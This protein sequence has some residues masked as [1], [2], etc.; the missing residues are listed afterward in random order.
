MPPDD[1]GFDVDR[2][3]KLL[4][5]LPRVR[6]PPS[7]QS[8][9]DGCSHFGRARGPWRDVGAAWRGVGDVIIEWVSSVPN[10]GWQS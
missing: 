4:A 1:L 2:Y 10:R 3:R 8:R 7:S 5:A 9:C 6:I